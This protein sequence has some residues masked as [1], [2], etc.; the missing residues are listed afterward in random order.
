MQI[1][2]DFDGTCVSHEFPNVG[3]DIGS[4][5]VLKELVN[6]GHQLILFTMRSDIKNVKTSN[7]TI[8]NVEGNYL[9]AAVEWFHKNEIQLYGINRN[10][11]QDDWT[12][13]PKAYGQ[14]YIDDAALGCPLKMDISISN[15]P[16]V[17]WNIIR[18]V[19]VGMNILK[20]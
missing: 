11:E 8:T 9:T 15:R 13:S 2:I 14:L 7:P 18:K 6:Q 12:A 5:S 3:N 16:F 19:L 1:C 17:D 20:Q 10:P 4:V